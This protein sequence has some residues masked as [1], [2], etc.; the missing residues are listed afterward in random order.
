M[1]D[2]EGVAHHIANR[3]ENRVTELDAAV[4]ALVDPISHHHPLTIDGTVVRNRVTV[5]PCLLD[6]LETAITSTMGGAGASKAAKNTRQVLDSDALHMALMIKRQIV[7]WCL[8]VGVTPQKDPVWNLIAWRDA[9]PDAG[10]Y[11]VRKLQEFATQIREK[12]DPPRRR[13]VLTPCPV[14]AATTWVDAEGETKPHPMEVTYKPDEILT[15]LRAVCRS[16]LAAWE[17]GEAV[18]ELGDEIA[19]VAQ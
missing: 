14:C 15:T 10:D 9:R 12:L 3:K 19:G 1:P 11:Y 17:G 8:P 5:L 18:A 16:C 2:N 13:E 7:D 4:S 6:Q